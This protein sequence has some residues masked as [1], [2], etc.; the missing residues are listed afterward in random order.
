M[1]A[2]PSVVIGFIAGL[3]LASRVET[4]LVPALLLIV[5]LPLSGT[6]GV[7]FWDRLPRA[8]RRRL[9]PGMEFCW[10]CRCSWSAVGWPSRSGPGSRRASSAT[11]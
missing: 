8:L 6:M 1:A 3:W 4:D 9:R 10:S 7:L 5:F 11:T 2:L